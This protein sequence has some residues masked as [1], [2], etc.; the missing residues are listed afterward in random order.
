MVFEWNLV[1]PIVVPAALFRNRSGLGALQELDQA[2]PLV[3]HQVAQ[4]AAG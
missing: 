2:Q 3:P 4:V 1:R